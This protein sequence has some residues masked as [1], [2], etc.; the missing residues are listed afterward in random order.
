MKFTLATEAYNTQVMDWP[1]AGRHIMAQYD[2]LSIV[3][4]KAFNPDIAE[5]AVADGFFAQA[6][7]Y[8]L[9]RMTWIK[10][11]FLWMMHRSG[12]ATKP[13]QERVLAIWLDRVGFDA[14]LCKAIPST[15]DSR[16]YRD[17]DQW[18][19]A[20]ASSSVRFQWDPD[21]APDDTQL[22]RR[23]LQIGLR[24]KV[25]RHY[26][27]GGWILNIEDI[28]D[29]VHEQRAFARQPFMGLQTPVERVYPLYDADLEIHFGVGQRPTTPPSSDC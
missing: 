12:W 13:G 26:V 6:P 1:Q 14:I 29:Y 20:V 17:A 2:D 28:T 19:Q 8:K 9:E 15:Y 25:A 3:V 23:A 27:H 18:Q 21:Y 11:G 7:G 16:V 22:S 4:Y 5:A 10:P 24:G